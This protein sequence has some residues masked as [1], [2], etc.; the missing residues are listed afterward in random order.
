[1]FLRNIRYTKEAWKCPISGD[2]KKIVIVTAVYIEELKTNEKKKNGK[3][4]DE[5]NIYIILDI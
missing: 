1:M 3:R 5:E 2:K 4:K